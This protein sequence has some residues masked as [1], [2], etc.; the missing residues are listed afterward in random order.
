[1]YS[2]DVIEKTIRGMDTDQLVD[3]LRRDLFGDEA[4]PIA[5]SELARRGIDPESPVLPNQDP[6]PPEPISDF[7]LRDLPVWKRFFTFRG[8]ASRIKFWGIVP[9][10]WL[11]FIF[12]RVLMEVLFDRVSYPV[13]LLA[14]FVPLIPIAWIHWATIVQR[15]HDRN[16]SGHRAWLLFVPLIG[17]L[18]ALIELGCL[19]G[20]PGPN[21]FGRD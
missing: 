9:V 3:R 16:K 5:E 19:P 13:L 6:L 12:L 8:R 14:V 17:P 18:W 1:M 4:R 21:R 15:L 2:L 11:C 20:T 7:S 10:A